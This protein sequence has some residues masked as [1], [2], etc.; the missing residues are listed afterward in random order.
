MTM[1]PLFAGAMFASA[2]LLFW[3]QPMFTK[4]VLPL[5]GGTPAVWNTALVFFQA[6]LL[7]GYL[8]AHV[9]SRWLS[10]RSQAVLHLGLLAVAMLLVLPVRVPPGWQPSPTGTPA[11]DLLGLL[12]VSLGLP[13]VALSATAPLLQRWFST[14]DAARS[15]DPYFLYAASNLGSMAALIGYP[16]VLEPRMGLAAQHSM[17]SVGYI[18]VG[19]LIAGAARA[20]WRARRGRDVRGKPGTAPPAGPRPTL[21]VRARWVLLALAPSSLLLGVTTYITTDVAAVPLLWVLPLTLY[22]LTFVLAFSRRS[23]L[24]HGRMLRTMPHAALVLTVLLCVAAYGRLPLPFMLLHLLVFFVLAMVCHGELA[25]TR[26][27]V[28]NLTEFYL[29]IALGGVLGGALN[30]L[31]APVVFDT[32][33]EYPL[34]LV[35][36]VSLAPLAIGE[37]RLVWGDLLW[38]AAVLLVS[39][40]I[41][42]GL[43]RNDVRPTLGVVLLLIC[44]SLFLFALRRR[45]LRFALAI[46][47]LTVAFSL[48]SRGESLLLRER[49]FYGVNAVHADPSGRYHVFRH[50]TTVHGAQELDGPARL[51]PISYYVTEGPVGDVFRRLADDGGVRRVAGIGLGTGCIAC[52]REEPQEWTF[53]EIDPVVEEIARQRHLFTYLAECAP[54]ARV[55]LGDARLSLR[56]ARPASYDLIVIDVF[57]SDA[58]PVHMMTRE[59]F[60]LYLDKLAPDGFLLVNISNSFLRLRPVVAAIARDLGLVARGRRFAPS[61]PEAALKA[62]RLPSEWVVLAR[63]ET[64]LEDLDGVDGWERLEAG[65]ARVWT[66]DYSNILEVLRWNFK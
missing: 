25:R 3:V 31:V 2:L 26:P 64:R 8:Y 53:Y 21:P 42:L 35:L 43:H 47:A 13:F 55:I 46:G 12:S 5:L 17:W 30:A 39:T 59:A 65:P 44:G 22:L 11:L 34:S 28:D 37:R 60:Q 52:Y 18:L 36:A 48:V 6:A 9:S 10:V 1:V 14:M 41:L 27:P 66:D 20:A 61:S 63:D 51:E 57:T 23:P 16:F 24:S 38:P 32:V 62:H 33:A 4:A 29:W 40:A 58:I 49:T 45:P 50:G 19:F 7:M 15:E 54:E 56:E